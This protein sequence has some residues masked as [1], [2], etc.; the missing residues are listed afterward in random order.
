VVKS[1]IV[2]L[3]LF[4][5]CVM[6]AFALIPHAGSQD[7]TIPT[8][9]PIAPDQTK[10][11]V[12]G[13]LDFSPAVLNLNSAGKYVTLRLTPSG[14][15]SVSSVYIPSLRFMG[16]VYAETCFSDHET[17]ADKQNSPHLVVKFLRADIEA[18]LAPGTDVPVFLTGML[19][20]GTPLHASGSLTVTA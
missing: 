3:L 20:D 12:D 7:S 4:S 8:I 2:T 13:V 16:L 18:V 17:G 10:P 9:V 19:V 1:V 5:S 14:D 6:S 11:S 15:W